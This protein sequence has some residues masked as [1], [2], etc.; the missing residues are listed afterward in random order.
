M[1]GFIDICNGLV[2]G[3][4]FQINPQKNAQYEI[5]GVD[6]GVTFLCYG[7]LNSCMRLAKSGKNRLP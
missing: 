5:F 4:Y 7:T 2:T 3:H 1:S 6:G